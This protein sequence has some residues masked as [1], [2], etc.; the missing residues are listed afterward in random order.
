[1]IAIAISLFFAAVLAL[2]FS[3]GVIYMNRKWSYCPQ[4]GAWWNELGDYRET[5]PASARVRES[6]LCPNCTTSHPTAPHYIRSRLASGETHGIGS[7]EVQSSTNP[8]RCSKTDAGA[9][10]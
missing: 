1:M 10:L 4:C 3:G 7:T 5:L 8:A 6:S 9:I 2:W